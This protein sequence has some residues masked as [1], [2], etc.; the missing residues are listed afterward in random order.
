MIIRIAL[1]T[2]PPAASLAVAAPL[3]QAAAS[4]AAYAA[5]PAAAH[6]ATPAA[7]HAATPAAAYAA[8]PAARHA[9]PG[10]I[11]T[12]AGGV[13][14]PAPARTVAFQDDPLGVTFAGGSLYIADGLV[15]RVNPRTGCLTTPAGAYSDN[16]LGFA[17]VPVG[18]GGPADRAG[19]G[20]D[21][22]AVAPDGNLVIA[23]T[24]DNRV[25]VVPARTGTFYG[26]H[27]TAGDIYT[28]AGDGTEG[29]SG[30]GG[31]ATKAMIDPN[32]LTVNRQ[33]DLLIV[34]SL[35][36]RVRLVTGGP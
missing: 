15:R 5:T 2:V 1:R 11:S 26:R 31:P 28:V 35:A 29:Y 23:D 6:A 17:N 27:M 10:I 3:A 8:A 22:M 30:D 4:A 12:I 36:G 24:R 20:A 33:G 21:T 34:D 32:G 9:G 13:G 16:T 18:D 14:G 19:L 7:A 25:R